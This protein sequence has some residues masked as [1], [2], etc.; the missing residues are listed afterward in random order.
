MPPTPPSSSGMGETM[1][2]GMEM[3][4]MR[5][6]TMK[7]SQAL[8]RWPEARTVQ[9]AR[10]PSIDAQQESFIPP[11]RKQDAERSMPVAWA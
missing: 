6:I 4:L 3:T 7:A 2:A 10:R 8:K 5:E 9:E 1:E 11:T